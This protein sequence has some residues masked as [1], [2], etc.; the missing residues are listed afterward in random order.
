MVAAKAS[1]DEFASV[2]PAASHPFL[3]NTERNE[4]KAELENREAENLY[5]NGGMLLS[6]S[7]N[8][9]TQE[10]MPQEVSSDPEQIKKEQAATIVQ[11]TFRGYLVNLLLSSTPFFKL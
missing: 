10:S 4:V 1:G 3:S 5:G 7:Q 8:A 11:A 2:P 6:G 9:E